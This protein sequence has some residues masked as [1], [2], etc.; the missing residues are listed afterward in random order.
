M[1]K[2][3]REVESSKSNLELANKRCL[4]F[5]TIHVGPS[6]SMS[7]IVRVLGLHPRNIINAFERC[8]D[9]QKFMH[10]LMVI[11]S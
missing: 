3:L 4:I 9:S 7:G 10:S 8:K 1:S 5:A 6:F 11:I 2:S